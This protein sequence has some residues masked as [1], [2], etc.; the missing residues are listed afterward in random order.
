MPEELILFLEYQGRYVG[1]KDTVTVIIVGLKAE[2]KGSL[3]IRLL[4]ESGIAIYEAVDVIDHDEVMHLHMIPETVFDDLDIGIYNIEAA[5]L[6]SHV[7]SSTYKIVAT[8]LI[9]LTGFTPNI[10]RIPLSDPITMFGTLSVV[11]EEMN[12]VSGSSE[13]INTGFTANV[14]RLN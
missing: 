13:L 6:N 7:L 11:G 3:I 1:S 5:F 14:G 10:V 9:T 2:H 12:S 8:P 4:N